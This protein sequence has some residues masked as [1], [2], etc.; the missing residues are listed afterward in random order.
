MTG[1][2]QTIF[3]SGENTENSLREAL[4]FYKAGKLR[5]ARFTIKRCLERPKYAKNPHAV[6]LLQMF[7][8]K[9]PKIGLKA[10]IFERYSDVEKTETEDAISEFYEKFIQP[11]DPPPQKAI[12]PQ[13]LRGDAFKH[14]P[15]MRQKDFV[16]NV[17]GSF[18]AFKEKVLALLHITD[19]REY[20]HTLLEPAVSADGSRAV[21][22]T[23]VRMD[24]DYKAADWVGGSS[25]KCKEH[26]VWCGALVYD[27]HTGKLIA[28]LRE[29]HRCRNRPAV[30]SLALD[31]KG[32]RLLMKAEYVSIIDI[33]TEK[34]FNLTYRDDKSL[35][36]NFLKNDRG[37]RFLQD[38]RWV[39]LYDNEGKIG[40]ADTNG[41]MAGIN[42]SIIYLD[43]TNISTKDYNMLLEEILN[44]ELSNDNC[45]TSTASKWRLV[46]YWEYE[47]ERVDSTASVEEMSDTESVKTLLDNSK[48]VLD[49]SKTLLDN[50]KTVLDYN[51]TVSGSGKTVLNNDKTVS[52]S[53]KTAL[54]IAATA[55]VAEQALKK[56]AAEQ[57]AAEQE[58]LI[59]EKG[60][61]LF[62]TYHVEI[63]AIEEG[64]MGRVWRVRHTGWNIDLALK[65]PRA[66]LFQDERQK[67]SFTHEC[68][69]WIDLGL[70]PHIVSCYYVREI[71]GVPSIFSEW[72]DGGSLKHW[73][74]D[75]RLYDGDEKAVLARVL[76]IA[77]QFER[78]LDYAHKHG[79]IHQ[80][81]K[82]DNLLL[83]SDGEAKVADFGIA[84]ARSVLSA[85]DAKDA[86]ISDGAT[87][88]SEAGAH[89]PAYCSPEQYNK[90]KLTRRTDIYS[91]AVSVLEIIL[92]G[93]LWGDG[94]TAGGG[95]DDY[96][97]ME[98]RVT[99]PEKMK[100][101]LKRCLEMA[102][103]NRPRDFGEVDSE[104][105]QIYQYAIGAPYP[106]EISKAAADTADS[107]NNR[108]LSFLDLGKPEEAEKCW[109]EAVSRDNTNA[110][111]L[112]N[113]TV[114]LWHNA[115]IDLD[116]AISLM[117]IMLGTA[118]DKP[119]AV[120]LSAQFYM[121]C[122][123]YEKATELLKNLH[124]ERYA[125]EARRLHK[126]A[127]G[128]AVAIACGTGGTSYFPPGNK[129]R[130]ALSSDEKEVILV[131]KTEIQ[132]CEIGGWRDGFKELPDIHISAQYSLEP[133]L[134]E[135][136]FELSQ[137]GAL[138]FTLDGNGGNIRILSV[139]T[140]KLIKIIPTPAK[141]SVIYIHTLPDNRE[142]VTVSSLKDKSGD[143]SVRV[144]GLENGECIRHTDTSFQGEISVLRISPNHRYIAAGRKGDTVLLIDLLNG[145]IA[146]EFECGKNAWNERETALDIS[147][148]PLGGT[149]LL[150]SRKGIILANT[151][152]GEII[153]SNMRQTLL[154]CGLFSYDGKYA[155][156]A[157]HNCI[158][159]W[160]MKNGREIHRY[161]LN[162][163]VL[164]DMR[165]A[166]SGELFALRAGSDKP[167][168]EKIIFTLPA[169]GKG[170]S[171]CSL[172]RVAS[173][174]EVQSQE[175]QASRIETSVNALLNKG[176]VAGAI[177]EFN[178]ALLNPQY[179]KSVSRLELNNRIGRYCHIKRVRGLSVREK[180]FPLDGIPEFYEE[181]IIRVA[182]RF[183]FAQNRLFDFMTGKVIRDFAEN[184]YIP[185]F[186]LDGTFLILG[187]K[188]FPTDGGEP[189]EFAYD[190]H[191]G[192]QFIPGNFIGSFFTPDNK[193]LCMSVDGINPAYSAEILRLKTGRQVRCMQI[194]EYFDWQSRNMQ[195]RTDG[196]FF[197][198]YNRD[199]AGVWE[200]KTGKRLWEWQNEDF[201]YFL[202]S[203]FFGAENSVI[204]QMNTFIV[205]RDILT[206]EKR[207]QI[208]VAPV[209]GGDIKGEY[210]RTDNFD[211]S[212][213][214]RYGAAVVESEVKKYQT[215]QFLRLY[216]IVNGR[217]IR[218]FKASI[219]EWWINRIIFATDSRYVL[220]SGAANGKQKI[221]YWNIETNKCEASVPFPTGKIVFHPSGCYAAAINEAGLHLI[222]FDYEYEFPGWTDWDDGALPYLKTFLS[223]YKEGFDEDNFNTLISELQNRGLGY[224]RLEGVRAKLNALQTQ[225]GE[226]S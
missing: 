222:S 61:M 103:E 1:N 155:F 206:G 157:G 211:I 214:G 138:L 6:K 78:G 10:I 77:I 174:K 150:V 69:A 209:T 190:R 112:Y 183:L 126:F 124:D 210:I 32:E 89:T 221:G 205:C 154:S 45:F 9:S 76:D 199:Y 116:R 68:E 123:D 218:E 216:E 109:E 217:V 44:T 102:E 15:A 180:F 147:F 97:E 189:T 151:D 47:D 48:T 114:Y 81:V 137:D 22:G 85:G 66:E 80:D 51:K 39:F 203:L 12:V 38:D 143:Y 18:K 86:D 192:N 27:L 167:A 195:F 53:G 225:V 131:S 140:G 139:K 149:I 178:K 79:L 122:R 50:G 62:D 133:P 11:S 36:L 84:G 177:E 7:Y 134:N 8:A 219:G 23:M 184:K 14:L 223:L 182:R 153:L 29:L 164:L 144:W 35:N 25:K 188:L 88:I 54:D 13:Q 26:I 165:A 170:E 94:R 19:K 99:V 160:D 207:Y 130:L 119:R 159:L 82:P 185:Y 67:T 70:H 5:E 226:K 63:D 118:S 58:A 87:I 52:D 197:S 46:F 65:R 100:T 132:T 125:A 91:W 117:D 113:Q 74:R 96:L 59:I 34:A 60:A 156:S 173:V 16:E 161:K 171:P 17:P 108:A 172:S 121:E 162:R 158:S 93:R 200:I 21:F 111:A 120:W 107:L 213:D 152:N 224:I 20:H 204:I 73:I 194:K 104:L 3:D 179:A 220:I 175:E 2:G 56:T 168:P 169:P 129:G 202:S 98:L 37:A 95:I 4:E 43:Y 196:K 75:G 49:G 201:S 31:S 187:G 83:T 106:R 57:L 176:N 72:M 215:E 71:G 30:F 64:G 28:A 146:R 141:E 198:V 90:G 142:L 128:M 136:I 24:R 212:H 193:V 115:K 163:K 105:L 145:K 55:S 41:K 181:S 186:S 110:D 208:G 166:A 40:I 148:H 42:G 191:E 33:A 92:G 135:S 101:L 127:S